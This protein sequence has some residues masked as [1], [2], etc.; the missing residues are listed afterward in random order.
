MISKD[1]IELVETDFTAEKQIKIL[2]DRIIELT[3]INNDMKAAISD[4]VNKPKDVV[5][6]EKETNVPIIKEVIKYVRS[7]EQVKY[8]DIL[9]KY[10]RL[11]KLYDEPLDTQLRKAK[12]LIKNYKLY[13][14]R[15][16]HITGI[17]ISK[18][19]QPEYNFEK[20]KQHEE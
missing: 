12:S 6:I 15:Y 2:N 20:V 17:T 8:D 14:K 9:K 5:I 10:E 4:Y 13:V 11:Q 19:S 16:Q 18:I 1:K 3:Q 7:P